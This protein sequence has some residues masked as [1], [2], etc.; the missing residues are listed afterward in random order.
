MNYD[1]KAAA[2][3]LMLTPDEMKEVYEL[4]FDEAEELLTA[5]QAAME[6][7]NDTKLAK[8]LH[9]LKG[10]SNNLRMNEIG[11]I[12]LAMEKQAVAGEAAQAMQQLPE[13]RDKI[14]AMKDFVHAFYA[15]A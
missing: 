1:V 9:A 2:E 12:A 6:E 3:E 15:G 13:L 10:S 11:Q 4:Y 8:A 14:D 5:C 7:K